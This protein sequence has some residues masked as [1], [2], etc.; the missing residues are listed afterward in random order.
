MEWLFKFVAVNSLHLFFWLFA[1]TT[2]RDLT[3][4]GG[5]WWREYF[6]WQLQIKTN[7]W[8]EKMV[9]LYDRHLQPRW[10]KVL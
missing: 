1:R 8:G 4:G 6:G 5:E 7:V 3:M 9:I 10:G 2:K